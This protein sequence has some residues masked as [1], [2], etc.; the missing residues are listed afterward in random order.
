MV[1]LPFSAFRLM[2]RS[3]GED[4]AYAFVWLDTALAPKLHQ[5]CEDALKIVSTI[6]RRCLGYR[7]ASEKIH[8]RG[9]EDFLPE[10]PSVIRC[11]ICS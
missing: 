1:G 7:P 8:A 10:V 2:L 4:G 11:R 5:Y 6:F 3:G 9:L